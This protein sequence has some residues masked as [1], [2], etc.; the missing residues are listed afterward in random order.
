M[1]K[2]GSTSLMGV[3]YE[4]YKRNNY[5]VL[6]LNQTRNAPV[7]TLADQIRFAH[8]ITRWKQRLPAVYH[9][10]IAHLDFKRLGIKKS[11]LYINLIRKP[12][13]R[14]VSYYYFLRFGDTFRPH[15]RRSRQGN[16]EVRLTKCGFLVICVNSLT[17]GYEQAVL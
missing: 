6:H 13:D 16:K 10:H 3:I 7:F 4:L 17:S 5:H 2:T 9:G 11:P 15:L 14:L 12:L 1:P 8:N